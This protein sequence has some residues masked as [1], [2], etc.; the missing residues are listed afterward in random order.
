MIY[1][2]IYHLFY[3]YNPESAEW[4]NITWGHSTSTDLVN[5]TIHP[6]ALLP[7]DTYDINGCWSGCYDFVKLSCL[8]YS[9]DRN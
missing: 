3:Q 7:S 4:G 1:E 8:P 5:W 9:V 6:P 2:G